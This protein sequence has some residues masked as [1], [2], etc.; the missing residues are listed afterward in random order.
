M[1]PSA[2][3]SLEAGGLS[4]KAAA[5]T[6][7]ALFWG[8]AGGI[9]LL[10]G[11][12]HRVLPSQVVDCD[13]SHDDGESGAEMEPCLDDEENQL[14]I[15]YDRHHQ[16]TENDR[17]TEDGDITYPN[18]VQQSDPSNGLSLVRPSPQRSKSTWNTWLP[19]ASYSCDSGDCYGYSNPCGNCF[20]NVQAGIG[21]HFGSIRPHLTRSV[22]DTPIRSTEQ[23]PLLQTISE[24]STSTTSSSIP[25]A[26]LIDNSKNSASHDH[27]H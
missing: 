14:N 10:S 3:H 6:L 13:H 17:A 1:L 15:T 16:D 18:G 23:T 27:H 2:R 22:T 11:I 5:W 25:N 12:M 7:I 9:Q 8:G 24:D 19:K 26:K 21:S 20:K 4:E